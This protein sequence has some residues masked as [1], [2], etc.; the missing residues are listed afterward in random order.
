M[1]KASPLTAEEK[2]DLEAQLAQLDR[3]IAAA[4]A[5]P[6]KLPNESDKFRGRLL[7]ELE[8]AGIKILGEAI[9]A[10]VG[11]KAGAL[12]GAP[13]AIFTSGLSIP[14]GAAIGG[15]TGAMGG[16]EATT[17]GLGEVPTMRGRLQAGLM[18]A[19]P[20]APEARLATGAAG[21]LAKVTGREMAESGLRMGAAST[22]AVVGAAALTG[23]TDK[24]TPSEVILPA[25]GG[26]AAGAAAR[27]V[28]A[29]TAGSAIEGER[30]LGQARAAGPSSKAASEIIRKAQNVGRDQDLLNWEA[31]GGVIDPRIVNPNKTT[32]TL[33]VMAGESDEVTRS[34]QNANTT[35]AT[36]IARYEIGIPA[37]AEFTLDI[38][39]ARAQELKKVY[40]DIKLLGR[41]A[42]TKVDDVEEARD[43]VRQSWRIW[44]EAK[45]LNKGT[46]PALL[47][48]AKKSSTRLT[49]L[50]NQLD[51]I[52]NN[53]GRQDLS[54]LLAVTRPQLAKIAVIESAVNPGRRTID[55]SVI[56]N[57][58][59]DAPKLLTGNLG[60]M[61]RIWDI[62]Q[63]AFQMAPTI[64][65][66]VSTLRA[67]NTRRL[68]AGMAL[69]GSAGGS[70][71][72]FLG[73]PAG[74]AA[75]G[76]AGA[77]AGQKMTNTAF[78]LLTGEGGGISSAFQ[79]GLARPQYGTNVPSDLSLF[80]A[81]SG[82][83]A[84]SNV[85]SF[86][87]RYRQE[88]QGLSPSR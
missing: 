33:Q 88:Q 72:Y 40:T 77:Y 83:P 63:D 36:E 11:Q 13:L 81:K 55:V 24:L 58:T 16:Y 52:V 48:T 51:V 4:E 14:V 46:T 22:G 56:G 61:G 32:K 28:G 68:P 15:F 59:K 17:R 30:Y 79:R 86:I 73:G 1:S 75:G 82:G 19:I 50:E 74:A 29:A 34:I 67:S 3:E 8:K 69:G 42:K 37:E 6:E 60:L 45:D 76:A 26:A 78:N 23:E 21:Q 38:F 47:E 12:A 70:A 31:I 80:L 27:Y 54:D 49:F 10:A 44:K 87:D 20:F 9:P 41:A 43:I 65:A 25:V 18:G 85:Q 39:R 62:Q 53:A 66:A 71:G 2:S 7:S 84:G 35:R 5:G 64:Q 57:L